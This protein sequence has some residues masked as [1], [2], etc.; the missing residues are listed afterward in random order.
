MNVRLFGV[1]RRSITIAAAMV[2]IIAKPIATPRS[3]RAEM[4]NQFDEL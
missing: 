1:T 2:G 4:T 3:R